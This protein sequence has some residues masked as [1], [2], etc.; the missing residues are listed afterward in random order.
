MGSSRHHSSRHHPRRT[1]SDEG[2]DFGYNDAPYY[3]FRPRARRRL[4]PRLNPRNM[5]S[6]P[7]N[8]EAADLQRKLEM[9][10]NVMDQ[11][12]RAEQARRQM[13]YYGHSHGIRFSSKKKHWNLIFGFLRIE[14]G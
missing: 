2:E 4:L 13:Q 8:T 12:A 3:S 1:L 11:E 10:N 6:D 9:L 14:I 7:E 5:R